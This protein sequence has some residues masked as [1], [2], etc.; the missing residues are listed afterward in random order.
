MEDPDNLVVDMRNYYESEVGHFE[1]A[2]LP[3][4]D[5]FRQT[6][7]LVVDLLTD[8]KDK[9]IL[10]YCTGGI[11]CE[12]ASAYLNH[13][14]FDDVNQLHGGIIEY[15]KQVKKQGLRSKFI[16]K[17]F[18]FDDRLGEKITDEVISRC[19][20]CGHPCDL[21]TNCATCAKKNDGC[22]TQRCQEIISL[23]IEE[24]RR[25]RKR[26]NLTTLELRQAKQ[27]KK[28]TYKSR[29]RPKLHEIISEEKK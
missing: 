24:Q 12:K 5:T 23:P 18:V 13:L 3:D 9:K 2:I 25:L 7:P 1:N 27:T 10:L 16:G 19:H 28:N 6:L 17:N 29:F 20:Q 8:A 11:R 21:H 15:A 14:G 22:C 4:G 26:K